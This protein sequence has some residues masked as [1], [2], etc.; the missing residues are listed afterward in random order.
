MTPNGGSE[1]K[2]CQHTDDEA[3]I[4]AE[5]EWSRAVPPTHAVPNDPFSP[6]TLS[7]W[8]DFSR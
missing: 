1:L 3:K 8:V 6:H 5:S 7:E 4:A 2:L